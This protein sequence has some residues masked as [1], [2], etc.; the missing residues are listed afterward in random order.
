MYLKITVLSI[1]KRPKYTGD[2]L[3]LKIY[4]F[5]NLRLYTWV[6]RYIKNIPIPRVGD[7]GCRSETIPQTGGTGARYH[8]IGVRDRLGRAD[9][10]CGTELVPCGGCARSCS[11]RDRLP[12][13]PVTQSGGLGPKRSR[14]TKLR[15][16]AGPLGL[17]CRFPNARDRTL[18]ASPLRGTVPKVIFIRRKL[19][20]PMALAPCDILRHKQRR[21]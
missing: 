16:R 19:F 9:Q 4:F 13:W 17:R 7:A 3:N 5:H 2:V 6:V 14:T 1:K 12:A 8:S 18:S 21:E 11:P 15:H 20:Y 10:G